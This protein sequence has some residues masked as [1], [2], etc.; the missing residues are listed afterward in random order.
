[1]KRFT[2]EQTTLWYG[3]AL[4]F[5]CFGNYKLKSSF[6]SRLS[7]SYKRSDKDQVPEKLRVKTSLKLKCKKPFRLRNFFLVK[8]IFLHIF[9]LIYRRMYN[10]L[11]QK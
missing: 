5:S 7:I 4:D 10:D 11:P 6:L 2:I 1:M 8:L 3:V 9:A